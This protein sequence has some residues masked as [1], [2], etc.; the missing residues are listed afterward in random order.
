[1]YANFNIIVVVIVSRIVVVVGHINFVAQVVDKETPAIIFDTTC[2]CNTVSTD[3]LDTL[4]ILNI[5]L[6]V[7]V[8][9][10]IIYKLLS[11]ERCCNSKNLFRIMTIVFLSMMCTTK[12][13]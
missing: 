7:K 11:E 1:M 9:D 3:K 10:I 8:Y 12:L 2:Y 4:D 13:K 6:T 5:F